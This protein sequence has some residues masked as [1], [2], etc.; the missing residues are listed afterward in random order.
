MST[1]LA[2]DAPSRTPFD[3]PELAAHILQ[4]TPADDVPSAHLA[5]CSLFHAILLPFIYSSLRLS[6]PA[7]WRSFLMQTPS[8]H[9]PLIRTLSLDVGT[10]EVAFELVPRL[11]RRLALETTADERARISAVA[12]H[13]GREELALDLLGGLG[14]LLCILPNVGSL[15]LTG[16][17]PAWFA[18]SLLTLARSARL[19]SLGQLADLRLP[20]RT[21][22]CSALKV[23]DVLPLS[24]SPLQPESDLLALP[25][26]VV[27]LRVDVDATLAYLV[28]PAPAAV[29]D[30]AADEHAP[31]APTPVSPGEFLLRWVDARA[32]GAGGLRLVVI[33]G[34]AQADTLAW[35]GAR[36][37][38]AAKGL[39][40]CLA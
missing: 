16:A 14:R 31:A 1:T 27:R 7:R 13:L 33:G 10:E 4:S 24:A 5:T 19:A 35:D 22:H 8:S 21:L 28:R 30:G 36:K 26:S 29:E 6:T 3:I 20:L 25:P 18:H 12:V 23:T 11:C 9:L 39:A 40:L 2:P 17:V 37:A 34:A 32:D 15:V 38:L